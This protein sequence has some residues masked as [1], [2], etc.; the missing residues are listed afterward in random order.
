MSSATPIQLLAA[1]THWRKEGC[2]LEKE[3]RLR[4]GMRG[5]EE[6]GHPS[7]RSEVRSPVEIYNTSRMHNVEND[8]HRQM[9]R[10]VI[11]TICR[12]SD[13]IRYCVEPFK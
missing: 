12:E 9:R 4:S 13:R 2:V 11:H 3:T 6:S 1:L 5:L 8:A 10:V 7:L